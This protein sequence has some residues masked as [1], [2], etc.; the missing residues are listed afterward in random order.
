MP[1]FC[2][3]KDIKSEDLQ[4]STGSW[5]LGSSVIEHILSKHEAQ[6]SIPSTPKI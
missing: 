3:R 5:R 4:I 1:A 6:G 2:M